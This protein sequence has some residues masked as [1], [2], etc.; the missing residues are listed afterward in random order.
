MSYPQI[1]PFGKTDPSVW[2][3]RSRKLSAMSKQDT[4]QHS[5]PPINTPG[6]LLANLPG[7]LGFY[8][9]DS[10]VFLT[11]EPSPHGIALGPVARVDF[12]DAKAATEE[13]WQAITTD[14]TEGVF[15]FFITQRPPSE[16]DALAEWMYGLHKHNDGMDIDA[17]WHTPEII[18]GG[19]YEI[20]FGAVNHEG[21]GPMKNWQE[22]K[23]PPLTSAPT[24]HH[25]V[26]KDLIPELTREELYAKL[27]PGNNQVGTV[28]G[29]EIAER[30]RAAAQQFREEIELYEDD[31]ELALEEFLD[32]AWWQLRAVQDLHATLGDVEALETAATWLATTWSRDLVI[33]KLC[34]RP[35]KAAILMLATA[36]TFEGVIRYNA[37]VLYAIAQLQMER[38][39]L[40]GPALNIL[41][42]EAP[43]HTFGNLVHRLYRNGLASQLTEALR[44]SS[45][46]ARSMALQ[47]RDGKVA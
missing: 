12:A 6:H 14:R 7:V 27:A 43:E 31:P 1:R 42:E 32:D 24:M 2:P 40:A 16:V 21:K 23:I 38:Y 22:G 30:A 5:Y 37:L 29:R 13:V 47:A 11:F 36:K 41:L 45:G 3:A 17:A 44:H 20:L 15:A 46:V 35:D 33:E 4:H 28:L 18:T 34:E 19:S 26:D 9:T 8:P 10:V 25:C 39:Q